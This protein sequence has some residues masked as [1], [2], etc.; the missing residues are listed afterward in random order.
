MPRSDVLREK[1]V[2]D[3]IP[4]II[5]AERG[6][7]LDVD[8]TKAHPEEMRRL[9]DLKLREEA[10]ELVE[11]KEPIQA[12]MEL[13]DLYAV[14]ECMARDRGFTMEM[15]RQEAMLKEEEKGGFSNRY[16]LFLNQGGEKL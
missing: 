12:L 10:D 7:E 5:Q 14:L 6:C 8:Y 11:A 1:L 15:I 3:K 16:V 4:S 13:G 9:L 2:R